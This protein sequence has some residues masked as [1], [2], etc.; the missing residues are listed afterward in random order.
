MVVLHPTSFF[1]FHVPVLAEPHM[2]TGVW[3]IRMLRSS[4]E[5]T[6]AMAADDFPEEHVVV[7]VVSHLLGARFFDESDPP[8]LLQLDCFPG[9]TLDDG[10]VVVFDQ[11]HR[12]FPLVLHPLSCEEVH[13]IRLLHED[14]PFVLFILEHPFN[15]TRP[16]FRFAVPSRYPFFLQLFCDLHRSFAVKEIVIDALHRLCL[17]WHNR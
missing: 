8:L 5:G 4:P 2:S 9:I 16:P 14:V 1:T 3:I 10:E 13:R 7:T 11:V 12:Q 6:A 17:R 15:R